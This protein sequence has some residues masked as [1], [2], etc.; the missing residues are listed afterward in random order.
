MIY[1]LPFGSGK[2]LLANGIPAK[3]AGGWQVTA[4]YTAASGEMLGISLVGDWAN[5]GST[6]NNTRPNRTCNGNLPS[7]SRSI[8]QWF[9]TSCFSF[10]PQYQF[11]DSGRGI[12]VGPALFDLDL[13][14]LRNF[15]LGEK[16]RLQFRAEAFNSVNHTNFMI[17]GRSLGNSNFGVITA[18]QPARILQL[19]LKVIF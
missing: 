13:G 9:Q 10:P 5:V 14:L 8:S 18:A 2:T 4:Y 6:T 19:A 15:G 3:I 12:I 11:G 17:P 7:G 1:D 16:R